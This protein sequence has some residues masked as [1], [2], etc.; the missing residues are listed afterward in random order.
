M[1]VYI[2]SYNIHSKYFDMKKEKKK[3]TNL[4]YTKKS[5]VDSTRIKQI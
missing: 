3:N 4:Y 2:H 5:S 1:C